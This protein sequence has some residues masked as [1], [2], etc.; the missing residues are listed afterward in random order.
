M[1]RWRINHSAL[2]DWVYTLWYPAILGTMIV[3][4]IG[5]SQAP[6][7]GVARWGEVLAFYFA[8][9]H[10]VAVGKGQRD[11]YRAGDFLRDLM[12]TT[13][14]LLAFVALGV[15]PENWA[16][17]DAD[18]LGH[19]SVMRWLLVAIF[20]LP[21]I[22]RVFFNRAH[23]RTSRGW[24]LTG[25]SLLAAGVAGVGVGYPLAVIGVALLLGVYV[26][27]FVLWS[28]GDA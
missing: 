25:L 5:G 3:G 21:P 23:L 6:Q 4:L 17:V 11:F 28:R 14:I 15:F 1:S 9:Q 18:W 26:V 12:E 10:S 19:P 7:D 27:W 22:W 16:W 8:S 20:L 2:H 13:L 24:W